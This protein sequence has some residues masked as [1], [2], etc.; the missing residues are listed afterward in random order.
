MRKLFLL[1]LVVLAS[2]ECPFAELESSPYQQTGN[3]HLTADMLNGHW[4]CYYPMYVGTVEFKSIKIYSDGMADIIMEDKGDT[5]Y[6]TVTFNYTYTGKY[7]TFSKG[8]TI[9]QFQITGFIYPEL[10]LRD[11]FGTYTWAKKSLL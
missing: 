9:Y 11:S 5:D 7:I 6:Y 4:Q 1:L 2:C 10:Y 3:D 8:R